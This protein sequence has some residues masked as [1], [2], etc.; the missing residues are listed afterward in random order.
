M[1]SGDHWGDPETVNV[2]VTKNTDGSRDRMVL[3]SQTKVEE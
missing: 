1:Q 2:A 3:R